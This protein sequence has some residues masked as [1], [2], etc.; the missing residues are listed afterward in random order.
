VEAN[1]HYLLA[2]IN[3][4]SGEP[5]VTARHIALYLAIFREVDPEFPEKAITLLKDELMKFSK[6]SGRAT[7]F[8]CIRD[9]HELGFICYV[10]AGH[11]WMESVAYLKSL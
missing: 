10:P 4:I 1:L 8:S 2:F 5:R 11:R 7:Y 6:I 9:L 3:G